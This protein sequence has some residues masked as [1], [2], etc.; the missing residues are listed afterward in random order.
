MGRFL[1]ICAYALSALQCSAQVDQASIRAA[2]PGSIVGTVV[3]EDGKPVLGPE[4]SYSVWTEGGE[5]KGTSSSNNPNGE[6]ELTQLPLGKVELN[7]AAALSGYGLNDASPYKQTVVL[8][9]ANP[10]ARVRVKVGP[11]PAMLALSVTDRTSGKAIDGFMIRIIKDS[12]SFDAGTGYFAP[13]PEGGREVPVS[14]LSDFLL[15]VTAKGYKSW[16]YSNPADPSDPTLHLESGERKA[17]QVTM[18]PK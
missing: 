18:Q 6:F 8:T 3:D 9:E 1:L 15:E 7:V 5:V 12:G 16:F 13:A 10:I 14:P 2:H 17:V 11:K 4:V